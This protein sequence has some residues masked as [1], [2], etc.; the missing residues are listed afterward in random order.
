MILSAALA[1]TVIS[2]LNSATSQ[3]LI[4]LDSACGVVLQPSCPELQKYVVGKGGDG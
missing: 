1:V 4:T 3:E 2:L